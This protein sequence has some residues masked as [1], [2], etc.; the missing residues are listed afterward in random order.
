MTL[1]INLIKTRVCFPAS[2]TVCVEPV[3]S[4]RVY[5]GFLWVLWFL[6]TVRKACW[7]GALAVLNSLAVYLNRC[8]GV[9]TGGFSQLATRPWWYIAYELREVLG[10][11][12]QHFSIMILELAN[13][14]I[15][16]VNPHVD[17]MSH[18]SSVVAISIAGSSWPVRSDG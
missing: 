3:R 15:F 8:Q 9:A 13:L 2:V 5:V 12:S 18:F 14:L 11:G 6:P 16:M 7:L 4:P 1:S 17:I 10:K